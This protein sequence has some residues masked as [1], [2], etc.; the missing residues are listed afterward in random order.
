MSLA[1]EASKLLTNKYFLYF[2]V[3][4]A[5]TN[6][7][8][9]LVTNKTNAV[10]F[11]ALVSLLTYQ[12]S[13]NMA[14]ILLVAIIA[15]NFLM[16]N[17]RMRE[18]LE[19]GTTETTTETPPVRARALDAIDAKDKD[20]ADAINNPAFQEAKNNSQ[21]KANVNDGKQTVAN[22]VAAAN[23][24]L[25][26][27]PNKIPSDPNNP[28]SNQT[29]VPEEEVEGFGE[30]MGGK[31]GAKSESFGPRLDYAATIEQSY[32]NLDNL[33]GSDAIRQLTSD[34][35]NLMKQQQT[36]FNT[37]NQMV[38]VLEGA[39]NMLGGFDV[40]GLTES[41]KNIGSISNAPTIA[42]NK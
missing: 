37:M 9:Y 6:V 27:K 31:K 23:E 33:L 16:A 21:L 26:T 15:T 13:K 35:K 30:K 7:L 8:G 5:A 2:M 32:G 24:T 4:L 22:A 20:V 42:T 34:T 1:T 38:P 12:F 25:K 29:T 40:K 3:F 28:T 14:V 10:I 39:K 17:K 19:N 41:L 18:G 36:L 11:F